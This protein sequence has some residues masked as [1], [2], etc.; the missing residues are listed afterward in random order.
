MD[1]Y[2]VLECKICEACAMNFLRER[3]QQDKIC[4]RCAPA[5]KAPQRA[6]PGLARSLRNS[7]AS[8]LSALRR[9]K[10]KKELG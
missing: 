8:R 3:G 5:K 4:P 7:E 9:W 1:G 2:R 10:A 6:I